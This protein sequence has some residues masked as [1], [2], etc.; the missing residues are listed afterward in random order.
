MLRYFKPVISERKN[1][2]FFENSQEGTLCTVHTLCVPRSVSVVLSP[3]VMITLSSLPSLWL[4]ASPKKNNNELSTVL[5]K[6][7]QANSTPQCL[8]TYCKCLCEQSSN[9][10]RNKYLFRLTFYSK[11]LYNTILRMYH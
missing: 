10:L 7:T 9:G 8:S 4:Q 2:V 11:F 5:G 6:C 3:L 1:A